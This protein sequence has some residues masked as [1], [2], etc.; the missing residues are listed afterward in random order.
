MTT[1]K[2]RSCPC[3]NSDH[4][5]RERDNTIFAGQDYFDRYP[6]DCWIWEGY[7]KNG[8]YG[9]IRSNGK[10][11]KTHRASYLFHKGPI[12]DG[13]KVCHTCD[14][15]RCINPSHLFLGTQADNLADAREKGRLPPKGKQPPHLTEYWNN[16]GNT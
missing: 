6:G 3:C 1:P 4:I 9:D 16:R 5:Q 15:P 8:R 12:P 14:N 10:W 13:M 11:L 2:L 7:S